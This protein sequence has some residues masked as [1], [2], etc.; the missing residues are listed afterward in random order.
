MNIVK[1]PSLTEWLENNPELLGWDSIS[2]LP[3]PVFKRLLRQSHMLHL[4]QGHEI[5]GISGAIEM[6][7]T[8]IVYHLAD[9]R[10][11]APDIDLD[12]VSYTRAPLDMRAYLQGG[13]LVRARKPYEVLSVSVHDSLDGLLLTQRLYP[14]ATQGALVMDLSKG[15]DVRLAVSEFDAEH[16]QA[17]SWLHEQLPD[18][19]AKLQYAL[20]AG[21]PDDPALELGFAHVR[22]QADP[23]GDTKALI[24]FA[25]STY[26][27]EGN[28][29]NDNN[30]DSFPYLLRAPSQ[31]EE[32]TQLMSARLL[33]R[34]A[35]LSGFTHQLE[36]GRYEP[37][38]DDSGL[39][40]GM[41]ATAGKLPVPVARY[42]SRDYRFENQATVLNVVGGL[43]AHLERDMASHRYV[44]ECELVFSCLPNN[45]EVAVEY[46]AT[47]ELNLTH[48]FYLMASPEADQAL[49]EGQ[50]FSPWPDAQM[51]R[52]IRGLPD[53]DQK[54]KVQAEDFAAHAVKQAILVAMAQKLTAASHEQWM[55]ALTFAGD[56]RLQPHDSELP[57][58]MAVFGSLGTAATFRLVDEQVSL[59][60]GGRH[61]FTV[62]NPP[63]GGLTW[64]LESLPGGPTH[65]GT[66]DN[67]DYR[68]PPRHT[69]NGRSGQVLVVATDANGVVSVA[70]VTVLR[71]SM[72][73]NPFISTV[74]AGLNQLLTAVSMGD[75]ALSWT[76]VDEVPGE[77]GQLIEQAQGQGCLYQARN[78]VP[79]KT[80]VL[81]EIEVRNLVSNDV[82]T[83]HVLAVQQRP[84]LSVS[85]AEAPQADGVLQFVARVNGYEVAATWRLAVGTGQ[86]DETTGR[87]RPAATEQSPGI[88]VFAYF[89][90]E[91]DGLLEGHLIMPLQAARFPALG[92]QL[93]AAPSLRSTPTH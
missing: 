43:E 26:G 46:R 57:A 39:L 19:E 15:E 50:F 91:E 86:I 44:G 77:S 25:S 7:W 36:N 83:V 21:S 8:D 33:L 90:A 47:F 49:L 78:D 9:Y 41:V 85:L 62:E 54:L 52:V 1:R 18:D 27:R 51:A 58:A 10:L 14:Q 11:S 24:V 16:I 59:L 56:N 5:N 64:T 35:F 31:T 69:L 87:Y 93:L 79:G 29:P 37:L 13:T 70:V 42:Q 88:L 3:L 34:N 17:G 84:G 53:D 32:A 76:L 20:V 60:A 68:A 2:A 6:E 63:E 74:Q 81:D 40:L 66:L 75:D 92:R 61:T 23:A 28:F 22:S 12:R 71:H 65:P 38:R 89:D 82:Q 4:R 45:D 30:E 55:S 67:G 72:T 73:V 48:W 80:Y